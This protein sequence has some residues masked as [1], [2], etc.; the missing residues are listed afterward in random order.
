[1]SSLSSS[2]VR[3]PAS[4]VLIWAADPDGRAAGAHSGDSGAPIWSGDVSAAI[5]I[6]AWAQ[7]PHGHGCGGLDARPAACAAQGLD[8]GDRAQPRFTSLNSPRRDQQEL[9]TPPVGPPQGR[10]G[11]A[12]YRS[13]AGD[14]RGSGPRAGSR[15]AEAVKSTSPACQAGLALLQ[16]GR[17]AA[18][19][20]AAALD[21][22]A[23]K[24]RIAALIPAQ[25]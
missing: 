6:V 3:E 18:G 1:V 16:A 13:A 2:A 12:Q 20:F 8:W 5:A 7:A 21:R 17:S 19:G 10:C 4:T 14:G 25:V 24:F 9:D 11:E 22:D 23:R 15:G